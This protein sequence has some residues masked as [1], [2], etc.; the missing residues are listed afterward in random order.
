MK[1][2]H[3][4]INEVKENKSLN[5]NAKKFAL[6]KLGLPI[7]DATI[8]TDSWYADEIA[9][10]RI[11][12]RERRENGTIA[13]LTFGVEIECYNAPRERVAQELLAEGITTD[14]IYSYM[15]AHNG[16][17]RSVFKLA[18]DGSIVGE[19]PVECVTPVLSGGR[20]GFATLKKA[21]AALK[22]VGAKVNKSTGLHVHVGYPNMTDEHYI[23]VF[24]NYQKL[25]SAIDSFMAASRKNN[26]YS[27]SILN[28]DFSNCVTKRDVVN[29]M[30]ERY[31]KV[32]PQSY[33]GTACHRGHGT[34]EFRQ[35]QGSTNY[36][37]ISKW[38]TFC[39][40]LVLWSKNNVI[41]EPITS[42]YDIPFL[43]DSEKM[44][45]MSR[46]E[47]FANHAE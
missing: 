43:N 22:R 6:V 19:N 2:L 8:L 13:N 26:F 32:N 16:D 24:K 35:H 18:P 46:N 28:Y 29:M 37:K 20:S 25:E 44:F 14:D 17:S 33:Y 23:N 38:A 9:A 12:A 41:S 3:E 10:A 34:I 7:A 47:Y 39:L 40:K 31:F 27:K 4:E 30:G 15:Q 36:E 45:F 21:C 11:A 1:S 5:R 42:I